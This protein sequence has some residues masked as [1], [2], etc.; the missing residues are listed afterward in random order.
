MVLDFLLD[1]FHG[2]EKMAQSVK[3]FLCKYENLNPDPYHLS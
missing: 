1:A 3:C 2:P